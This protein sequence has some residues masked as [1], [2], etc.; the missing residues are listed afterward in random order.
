M[1]KKKKNEKN[2]KKNKKKN[3]KTKQNILSP[4]AN[5][6][7][8]LT[9]MLRICV[10]CVMSATPTVIILQAANHSEWPLILLVLM[11]E[12]FHRKA[13]FYLVHVRS[14]ETRY[15]KGNGYPSRK[16]C[17]SLRVYPSKF[18]PFRA[19][20]FSEVAWCARKTGNHKNYLL[21]K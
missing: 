8:F 11:Y 1:K 6:I 2:K 3:N 15:L 9:H 20:P 10:T 7:I 4:Y 21:Y 17:Q 13:T 14:N 12:Q 18:F 5:N 19:D 16:L